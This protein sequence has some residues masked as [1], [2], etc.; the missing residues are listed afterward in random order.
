MAL[1]EI[2]ELNFYSFYKSGRI[3]FQSFAEDLVTEVVE[4]DQRHPILTEIRASA[5]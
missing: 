1:L 3:E 2:E 4:S 5:N